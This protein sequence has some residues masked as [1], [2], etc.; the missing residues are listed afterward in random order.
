MMAAL[1]A[2]DH[3]TPEK[4]KGTLEM[5]N[6]EECQTDLHKWRLQAK[7]GRQ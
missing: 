2:T 3:H 5:L 4:N 1:L 7:N 6:E